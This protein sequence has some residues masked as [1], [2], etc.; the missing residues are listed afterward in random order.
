MKILRKEKE[1][2]GSIPSFTS[3]DTQED[4]HF[5]VTTKDQAEQEGQGLD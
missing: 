4:N 1:H 3:L 2:T 5:E